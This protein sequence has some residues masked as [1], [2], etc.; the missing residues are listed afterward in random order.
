VLRAVGTRQ[1]PPAF[2]R[3]A[4]ASIRELGWALR[5]SIPPLAHLGP[6]RARPRRLRCVLA[7]LTFI[8]PTASLD[9]A[10]HAKLLL[11]TAAQCSG[12]D[13]H[14]PTHPHPSIP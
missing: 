10:A 5:P 7:A 4:I 6:L 1:T 11:K 12:A 14:P 2:L 9:E 3:T 8:V 13:S